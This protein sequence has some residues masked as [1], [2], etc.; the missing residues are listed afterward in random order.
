[1]RSLT[2]TLPAIAHRAQACLL[3]RPD[4]DQ[5]AFVGLEI[6]LRTDPTG[7]ADYQADLEVSGW[8][9]FPD[10]PVT[11]DLAALRD[12]EVDVNGYGLAL[13][14]A[15]FADDACGAA[16]KETLAV[17]R[18]ANQGLRVRLV[19]EPP[20]L[21]AIHWERIYH[22][23]AGTWQPLGST[24]ATPFSRYVAVRQWDRPAPIAH[25]PLRVAVVIASPAD[26]DSWGLDAIAAAERQ[27]L[28]TLM[29]G[30][31][32]V[33]P[34]Y[35]ESGSATPPTLNEIRRVLSEGVDLIHFLCHG[36][37]TPNGTV[38][39]L[40]DPA[41]NVDP[42][43]TERLVDVVQLPATQPA[44]CFLAACESAARTRFDALA[45]LGPALVDAGGVHAAVAMT[46]L[47]GL[48]TAQAFTAHFYTRLLAHGRVD[49]AVNEARALVQ[50]EWDWAVPVLF[51]RVPDGRLLTSKQPIWCRAARVALVAMAVL[52]IAAAVGW[53]LAQPYLNPTQMTGRFKIAVADFGL[54]DA[55]GRVH[56]SNIGTALSQL[57]FDK[58]N[59]Q[60]RENYA[61]FVDD[62]TPRVQIWHDSLGP[63]VK[64]V[65]FGVIGGATPD[66][67]AA[68]ARRLADRINADLVIY[69]NLA[70]GEESTDL[71]LEFYNN[72]ETWQGEP[73][74]VTG[75]HVVGEPIR[76]PPSYE[77]EQVAA[78]ELLD[79]QLSQRTAALFWITVALTFDIINRQQEA[80]D[81]LL[82]AKNELADWEDDDG[83]AL[84]EYFI[85]REAFWLRDYDTAVAALSESIR[86]KPD[87]ANP[88]ITLGAVYYD[89]A[90]LFFTPQPIPEGLA[91][92]FNTDHLANGAQSADEA[93][94]LTNRA[95]LSVT[96]AISIAPTSPWP[97]I[98]SVA[99][100][101]QGNNYRLKGQIHLIGNEGDAAAPWFTDALAE[102][103]EA[104]DAFSEG[105][106]QQY[107][108]WTH[109]G[110]GAT[111]YLQALA[112]VTEVSSGEIAQTTAQEH[113]LQQSVNLFDQAAAEFQTC[114]DI[115]SDVFDLVFQ[116]KVLD[117]GC[118]YYL[119]EVQ[120]AKT[121]VEQY[122]EG[123]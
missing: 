108:A 93:M 111:Y 16:Y 109:L 32:T 67:R 43:T 42:V 99:H 24:A 123:E 50:D 45:P 30:L 56:S 48:N 58:L 47:V 86:L 5:D 49:V 107:A 54:I 103:E 81:T 83:Q 23:Y 65:T 14:Q 40:E 41:G 119:S 18:A 79:R 68:R 110:I 46:D 28:H 73:D 85:G 113:A 115:G 34:I 52:L 61:D 94:Q 60:Y 64:N 90:Q 21:Q 70:A 116:I 80:L 112:H 71:Q 98:E 35:L 57:V 114:I 66:V 117:C 89:K 77:T 38:L 3:G 72:S 100:L 44:C 104:A 4:P 55:R 20:E 97:P 122:L 12:L 102:F 69:G 27:A 75:R 105:E 7:A 106:Q 78:V 13:G 29:D 9:E 82:Y 11:L 39:Y 95:I 37:E 91:A 92:C 121:Q 87:Y 1:M 101:V 6:R 120:K 22:P 19:V 51:M 74:A 59:Q 63:D 31:G 118:T 17:A 15:L 76:L 2:R 96:Q 10:L 62:D 26:L 25:R 8:R 53:P 88:H 33:E 36:A 84:L